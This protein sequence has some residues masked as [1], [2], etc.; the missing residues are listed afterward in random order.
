MGNVTVLGFTGGIASGKSSRCHHLVKLAQHKSQQPGVSLGVAYISADSVGHAVY[1]PGKDV[2]HQI[3]KAFGVDVLDS[4]KSEAT[5]SSSSCALGPPIDRRKLGAIVFKDKNRMRVLNTI[6]WPAIDEALLCECER[7]STESTVK[8]GNRSTLI[9]LEAAVL[10]EQGFVKHCTD[11]WL[12]SCS[13]DEAVRR[14][15][16]RN[17][18]SREDALC[19]IESQMSVDDR[20]RFLQSTGFAGDV[21]HFDT[22]K[23]TLAAGLKEVS[24]AFDDYWTTKLRPRLRETCG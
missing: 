8:D 7:I 2:Y 5:G 22:T 14:L 13:K 16:E 20:L 10:I 17:N 3:V 24:T 11:V 9:I 21:R 1:E 12:A 18:L 4:T 19:R 6:V 23:C 15:A